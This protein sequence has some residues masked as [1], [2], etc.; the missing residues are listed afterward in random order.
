MRRMKFARG[1]TLIVAICLLLWAGPAAARD[2]ALDRTFGAGGA[3][4]FSLQPGAGAD[5]ASSLVLLSKGR[6]ATAGN[7]GGNGF[8]LSLHRRNG[9]LI[10]TF[11][12]DGTASVQVSPGP[13]PYS[14]PTDLARGP[15][16]RLLAGGF[17]WPSAPPDANG[18]LAAFDPTG[19]LAPSFGNDPPNPTGDGI[20]ALDFAGGSDFVN[21]VAVDDRG[22]TLAVGRTGGSTAAAAKDIFVVRRLADG[23]PDPSFSGGAVML[24]PGTS[25]EADDVLILP[26]GRI[27]VAGGSDGDLVL[28]RLRANGTLDPSFGKGGIARVPGLGVE[29]GQATEV[30]RDGKGRLVVGLNKGTVGGFGAYEGFPA[31]AR[32]LPGGELDRSFSGDG[33]RRIVRGDQGFFGGIAATAGGR[34]IV[35]FTSDEGTDSQIAVVRLK[36]GGGLDRTFGLKGTVLIG[37]AAMYERVDA[38]GATRDRR[39][40]LAGAINDGTDDDRFLVR[41][42]GDTRPPGTKILAGPRGPVDPGTYR[43]RFRALRDTGARYECSLKAGGGKPRFSPCRSSR[44]VRVRRGRSYEFA[45][46]AVDPA[47]NTDR[48]PARISFRGR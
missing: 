15:G 41:L 3:K 2:G 22:R 31:V 35:T 33:H 32:F 18:A 40:L 27:I 8:G 19:A 45:V 17:T 11:A 14:A 38:L 37:R 26:D 1:S 25:D 39:I 5:G 10:K 9:S 12:G 13:G 29:V 34:I 20:V 21:A 44:R 46:R 42:L 28:A 16:A 47:G 43:F 6:F 48:T 24:N 36:G 23:S 4:R 30:V 7:S